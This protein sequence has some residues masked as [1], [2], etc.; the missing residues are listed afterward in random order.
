MQKA[1]YG[2]DA[3]VVSGMIY[4]AQWD[5]IMNWMK[6]VQNLNV[7]GTVY[8]IKDSSD[9]GNYGGKSILT[10]S[11]PDYAVKNIFDLAGNYFEFT[12]EARN[13]DGRVPR[14]GAY[15][16]TSGRNV[17]ASYRS[18]GTPTGAYDNF[19]SRLQLY[20]K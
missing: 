7:E 10:G 16:S 2:E 13:D 9:M 12:Q 14:G 15:N 6:D 11:N 8:Y 20:I 4:G 17:P 3:S 18:A 1:L 5:V 19:S